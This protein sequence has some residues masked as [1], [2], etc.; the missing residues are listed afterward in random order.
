MQLDKVSL[1]Q[2]SPT[3]NKT[4][5]ESLYI[6]HSACLYYH[7]LYDHQTLIFKIFLLFAQLMP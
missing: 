5:T 4:K 1:D 7:N 2:I 3:V 6:E